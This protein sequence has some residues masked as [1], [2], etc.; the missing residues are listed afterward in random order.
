[1]KDLTPITTDRTSAA[2]QALRRPSAAGRIGTGAL[3]TGLACF[4][5]LAFWFVTDGRVLEVVPGEVVRSG[6]LEPDELQQT[7]ER[8]GI[9][10]VVSLTGNPAEDPWLQAEMR[11]TAAAGLDHVLLVFA[12]DEWPPRP[13]VTR[14]VDLIERGDHPLLLH[15]LRGV[16]RAGWAAAVALLLDDMPLDRALRQL[17]PWNGHVCDRE[18]CPLHRF[19]DSY[20]SH[21]EDNEL[22]EGSGQFRRWAV[23]LYC[24]EPYNAELELLDELPR[25]LVAAEP[26]RLTVR[27]RNRGADAWRMT[28]SRTDGV[29]L[30]ARVIGPLSQTLDDPIEA[31]RT[32][33]GPAVDIARSILEPG[34]VG[35]GEVRDFQLRLRTPAQPGQYVLQIDMVDERVRWFSDI[36]WPGILRSVE[37]IAPP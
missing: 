7:I 18:T 25:S 11:L 27:V 16:D 24:P 33:N 23:D 9:R 34:I 30:G 12:P 26:V 6:R 36:G 20:R 1:M 28:E 19:F 4:L 29:R 13:R 37:V 31:F 15:C 17:S 8:F 10:T 14:L 3:L 21:L 2:S 5:L 22:P 35:P 32:P